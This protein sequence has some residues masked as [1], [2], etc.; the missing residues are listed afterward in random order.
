MIKLVDA[1]LLAFTKLRTRKLRTAIT[2]LLASLLFGALVT[3]SLVMTGAFKSVDNFR[4]DGLT[5]RYIVNVYKP[6]AVNA[7]QRVV[8][9]PTIINEAKKRYEQLV[10]SKTAEAK[11]LDIPYAQSGDRPPYS[12]LSDGTTEALSIN[13]PNGIVQELLSERFK[14]EPAFDDVLLRQLARRHH[15]IDLFASENYMIMRGSS[16]NT[17]KDDREIYY[18]QSDETEIDTHYIKPLIDGSTMTIAPPEI[19]EPFMLSDNAGWRPDSGS[20]PVILA[21]D[22]VEQLLG[23]EKMSNKASS[24][25]KLN[26]LKSVRERAPS[27]TVKMC[28]RNEASNNLIQ[29]TIQ[30][31]K[32]MKQREKDKDYRKPSLIYALPDPSKC[33]SASVISD[34]R[35]SDEKKRDANQKLFDKKFG[36]A[37]EPIN[38]FVSFKIVGISPAENSPNGPMLNQGSDQARDINDV[39]ENLL[40]I[41]GIGQSVPRAL[42]DQLPDKTKYA[43]LFTYEPLYLFGNEDNKV[44]YAEFANA[45]DA[46]KFIDNHSC[47][48]QYDNSCK[49]SGRPYQASLMFSNSSALDDIQLKSSQGFNYA[50]IGATALATVIMWITVGRTI[51]DGRRESAIFRAIGFKRLDIAMVYVIYTVVLS[52]LV[53]FFAVI[54]GFIGACI[55]DM[56]LGPPLTVQ[57]QY[58]LGGA[59]LSKEVNLIMIDWQQLCQLIVACL[60]T[61]VFSMIIPLLRNIRRNPMRD[62]RE[63]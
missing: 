49:P 17:L 48:M 37:A 26:R 35:T 6:V 1:S 32:E 46:E 55:V 62:M 41:G 53:A 15:S 57:L 24:S 16:L 63:E 59:D 22:A 2:V 3:A 51:A 47:T 58:G 27:L 5:S 31:Q 45:S 50:I 39:L 11:R 13:D 10:E 42:Y 4:K 30:Q 21:Q 60:A 44:R 28:Y 56:N 23:L 54:I 38:Y 14:N 61:G 19:T 18:D 25:E 52:I 12:V 40:K 36:K 8:R 20:L 34:T 9:D 7:V 29:T 33:E 43:D